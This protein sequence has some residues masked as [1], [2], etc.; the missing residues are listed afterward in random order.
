MD[1]PRYLDGLEVING[2]VPMSEVKMMLRT[3]NMG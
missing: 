1:P 3:R 2:K